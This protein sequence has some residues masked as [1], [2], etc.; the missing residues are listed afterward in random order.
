MVKHFRV[1]V[2]FLLVQQIGKTVNAR[3]RIRMLLAQHR[4][5]QRQCLSMHLF[6]LIVFALP[7]QHRGQIV[8]ARQRRWMLLTQHLLCFSEMKY[9]HLVRLGPPSYPEQEAFYSID[10]GESTHCKLVQRFMQRRKRAKAS[11]HMRH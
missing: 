8:H 5:L 1:L 6:G 4:F 7:A 2:L 3:Q 11:H 9:S 10:H